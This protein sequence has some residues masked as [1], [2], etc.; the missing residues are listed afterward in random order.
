VKYVKIENF[1]DKIYLENLNGKIYKL[2]II[3][4][5]NMSSKQHISSLLKWLQF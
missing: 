5:W 3:K 2:M 1:D 4:R